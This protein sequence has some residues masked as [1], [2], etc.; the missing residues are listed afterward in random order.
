MDNMEKS[1]PSVPEAKVIP[2][3]HG[4][5]STIW[6]I[7]I[8]AAL[9]GL[10]IGVNTY[11]N[12]GPTITIIF[13]SADG[14]EAHK[15]KIRYNGIEVGEIATI[16]ISEDLKSIIATAKMEPKTE[17][18]LRKDTE[19]WV[20]RP[21]ISGANISGL[22][23]LISGAYVGVDIGK[24]KESERHF[25]ALDDAPLE[26]DGI[27]GH[28][29]TLQTPQLGSLNKGTPIF[30]RRLQAG[31][32][33]D[34]ELDKSG[35]FLNVKIFVQS[36]YDQFVTTDTR[37]WQASGVDVSLTASGLRVRTESFLSILVGGIAFE[38]PEDDGVPAPPVE[39]NTVFVLNKD[40]ETAFR[41]PAHDPQT[42]TLVFKESLRGL[43]VGAPVALSGI[44][45]GE[46]T[47]IHAQ[48]DSVAHDFVAPVTIV[49]DPA[50]YGVD[51]LNA[52]GV[53][54]AESAASHRATLE[55]FVARGLRAQ[56]KTGS[57][58]TG[59]RY[60]ALEFFP[61]AQPV[62]LDWSKTPLQFPTQ[63]GSI[64][65]IEASVVGIVKKLD[66]IPFGEIGT[67][68]NKTI[69]G[70]QGTLTNANQLLQN[71]SQLVAPGA[72]L[73]AQLNNTLQQVGG[74]AQALRIL[75]DYLERHPESLLKGKSG[76][77]Q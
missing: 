6:V 76:E 55:S 52:P 13:K 43:D 29:F 46:V 24:S 40:R 60:I 34:Y 23:T 4:R 33:A 42:F 69:A 20:V 67:N 37:F 35:K 54:T 62:A 7:P 63:P 15:T 14:L 59:S 25:K 1:N 11:R 73:D 41:P 22:G 39:T 10:W 64:E 26:I 58:V 28:Y 31:E 2:K 51:F 30:Y 56:L 38:T 74:A 72:M 27:T 3:K 48:F 50:R 61:N 68:L 9:V 5:F 57:L 36:P 75:A 45:I 65:S 66:Q 18:F 19:F 77:A 12:Q 44:T 71:S 49:V 8:A 17:E 70:A 16:R 21:Q 47:A 32:V 53:A